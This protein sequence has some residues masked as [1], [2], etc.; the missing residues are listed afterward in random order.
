MATRK[1]VTLPALGAVFEVFAIPC[2]L[3]A[4]FITGLVA[5]VAAI[6]GMVALIRLVTGK[7]PFLGHIYEGED[8]ERHLSFKLVAP[9]EAEGL[10]T[11]Y[12]ERFGDELGDMQ[13]EIKAIIE[14]ARGQAGPAAEEEVLEIEV[15]VEA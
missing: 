11:E 9:D 14:E 8:G 13:S 3:F 15:E 5:P 2:N 1:N 6:A 7:V 12:K 10:F 4:G